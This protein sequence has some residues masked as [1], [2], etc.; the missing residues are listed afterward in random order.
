[1]AAPMFNFNVGVLGHVDSGK[2][3][4]SKALSTTASTACFDKNPQSKERG[5]TLD[6]GF[7]SFQLD[8]PTHLSK[9]GDSGKIQYTLVDCPGHASLI[10]TIIGGAQIIDLMLLVVDVIK[11]VQTQTAECLVIGEITCEKMIVVLNKVDLVPPE[12]KEATLDKMR[13]R[14]LKTLE[15]TRFAGSPIVAVA[16]KPGGPEA[17]GTETL[18]LQDL[19]ETL[20]QNTY[21][22]KRDAQGPFIFSVDHCFSIRG[23]GTIMTGTALNGGVAIND[24]IEIPSMK[25]TKKFDPSQLERGSICTPGALPSIQAAIISMVKIPYYKGSISS[26]AK[27]HMTTGHD[28]VMGR[29][30]VFGFYGNSVEAV[31]VSGL[32]L[33]ATTKFDMSKE[34]VYQDELVAKNLRSQ[35]GDSGA[36]NE[37]PDK[38]FALVQF[39]KPVICQND[40]LIIGSKLDTDIHANVCRIAFHGEL[41]VG[42][43]DPKYAETVL[44]QVKVYKTK[45]K[46][47]LVERVMDEYTV[48]GKNMFKK[49]TNLATFTGLK[50]QLSTG[51]DGVIEGGFGQSGKIKIRI[52]A[53]LP[54]DLVKKYSGGKKRSKGK[55]DESSNQEE[56]ASDKEP[57]KIFLTF[58]RFIFDPEKKM[59]QT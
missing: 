5:I 46:D 37:I 8:L 15:G 23:Q 40:A 13:K 44:P 7:S 58:K 29:L 2:T 14:L 56:D 53:G 12:K 3:S 17:D 47:G 24:M 21:T 33:D 31:G 59:K 28:T 49:E 43:T 26:K 38:Q 11:G 9:D 35:A 25:V 39:E 18:G 36:A 30:T 34:Y 52:P 16:A 51:H 1:M 55:T 32:K 57:I 42:M 22:P 10:K 48:I 54:Q 4:L 45:M 20:K 41:L 6:L 27:F 19:V 50:V